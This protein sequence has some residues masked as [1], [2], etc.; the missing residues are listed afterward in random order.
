MK[1]VF[2]PLSDIL[3]SSFDAQFNFS[4]NLMARFKRPKKVIFGELPLT[5]TGKIQ[6]KSL[7]DRAIKLAI[8]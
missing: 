7:R 4:P 3:K 5:A 8:D 1:S 2:G 6:K